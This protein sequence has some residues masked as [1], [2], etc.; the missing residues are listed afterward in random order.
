M[1]VPNGCELVN[2][3]LSV[4]CSSHEGATV[5]ATTAVDR[6]KVQLDSAEYAYV[7]FTVQ[8]P[9]DWVDSRT[10]S[11]YNY[12]SGWY[13]HVCSGHLYVQLNFGNQCPITANAGLAGKSNSVVTAVYDRI[14][15]EIRF[16]VDGNDTGVSFGS[17]DAKELFPAVSLWGNVTATLVN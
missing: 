11:D 6:F 2:G 8:V 14:K 17:V 1:H 12:V 16:E 13:L 3:D 5:H 4:T 9:L 7:G 15:H 10:G